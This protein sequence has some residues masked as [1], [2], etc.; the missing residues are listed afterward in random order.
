VTDETSPTPTSLRASEAHDGVHVALLRGVNVAGR[1]MVAMPALKA[2]F[3]AAGARD[4]GTWNQS[5]NVLFRAGPEEARGIAAAVADALAGR[6]GL[7]VA[8]IL[9]T[10]GELGAISRYNPFLQWRADPAGLHV[11]FLDAWPAPARRAAIDPRRAPP[12]ELMLQGREVYLL[13]PNG[14]GRTRLTVPYLEGRLGT[15]ATMRNWRTVLKL[16]S[17]AG[18][19]SP[20]R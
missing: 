8:I 10:A 4:V 5:G 13:C 19:S 15:T 3:E 9:R 14:V 12:D 20:G 11:A 7:R 16:A 1:T 18:G 17:L 6:L 2:M